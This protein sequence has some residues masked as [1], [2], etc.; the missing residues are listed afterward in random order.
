MKRRAKRGL[1][2]GRSRPERYDPGRRLPRRAR[3]RLPPPDRHATRAYL[4]EHESGEIEWL[5]R[6]EGID[7]V[8]PSPD[9]AERFRLPGDRIGDAMVLGTES[10]VF[11][12]VEGGRRAVVDLRSHGSWYE[13]A[14]P[15]VTSTGAALD[16]NPDTVDAFDAGG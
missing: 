16:H 13:R 1:H 11:G 12:P 8:L 3:P 7:E 10:A 6:F 9:A 2:R 4:H 15:S 14:A 5:V